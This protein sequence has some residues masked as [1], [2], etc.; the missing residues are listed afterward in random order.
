M[1]SILSESDD[2]DA[3]ENIRLKLCRKL[4][5]IEVSMKPSRKMKISFLSTRV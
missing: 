1:Y 4:I 5:I 3:A 2:I